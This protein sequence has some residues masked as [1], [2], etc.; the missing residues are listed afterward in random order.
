M[1][2][3]A[4]ELRDGMRIAW[5]TP[6]DGYDWAHRFAEAATALGFEPRLQFDGAIESIDEAVAEQLLADGA[7]ADDR[8]VA[9]PAYELV[10][11]PAR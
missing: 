1:G 7:G 8:A 6:T 9:D 4:S 5:D 3:P 2:S 10:A 11:H